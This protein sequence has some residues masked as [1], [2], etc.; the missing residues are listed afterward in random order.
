MDTVTVIYEC[1]VERILHDGKRATALQTSHGP[2]LLH[3]DSKL[4]LAMSTLP[5]TTLVLNSF[6][7]DEFPQLS[8]VGKRFTAHFVS[9]VVARVPRHNLSHAE[10]APKVEL[11]AVYI[12]GMAD[13]AQYHL[14]LS[15]VA[16]SQ[17]QDGTG[18]QGICKKYS[19]NSIPRECIDVSQDFVVVSCSSLGELDYKNKVNQFNLIENGQCLTTNGQLTFRLNDQDK[20]LW[21]LM[22]SITSR[23]M[24]KL[25]SSAHGHD[26]EYWHESDKSWRKD[27]PPL[28]QI[29]NTFLVHDASTMWIGIT[30]DTEAP[31]G[32][33]YRLQGVE[34]VYITGGALWPTGGSWNPV[35]TIVAMA[36]HLADT[37]YK[38][39]RDRAE[40]PMTFSPAEV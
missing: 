21:D 17:C 5:A 4:I 33:D 1:T 36:M 12:A 18:I 31:V 13:K 30:G 28:E 20:Q 29:R 39:A 8:N 25:S 26:L 37:I 32:L 23:V 16:Y 9:S 24:N 19:A 7:K 35:L 3:N 14:Q 2:I 40:Q 11:G 27:A 34:N 38:S 6:D 15:G 10:H 22:D